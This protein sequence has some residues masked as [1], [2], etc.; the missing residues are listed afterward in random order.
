MAAHQNKK[1]D[2]INGR[3]L[4][5]H[6]PNATLHPTALKIL[7]AAKRLLVTKGFEAITLEAIAAEAGVNKASTRYYFGSKAGLMG[8]I[9]DE[10]VLD[11]CAAVASDV[12]ERM[13]QAERLDSFIANINRMATDVDSYSGYFDILPH[14]LRD[15]H[16]RQRLVYLYD[17]WYDWNIEW[18]GL[19]GLDPEMDAEL[20]A[21]GQ[22]TAAVADGIAVQVEIHGKEYD[23]GPALAFLR[24]FLIGVLAR[25]KA[26]VPASS[27][28]R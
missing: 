20:R 9:V 12:S 23:P 11:E 7:Q 6:D 28:G 14:A 10:I 19:D 13:S 5:V 2:Q 21:L 25:M 18:L 17:L 8:A 15:R 27:R 4:P 16:L 1:R 22:F 24:E 3:K 26:A